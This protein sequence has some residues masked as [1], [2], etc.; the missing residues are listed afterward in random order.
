LAR[1]DLY[2]AQC[3]LAA[4]RVACSSGFCLTLLAPPVATMNVHANAATTRAAE[5]RR[6]V[7]GFIPGRSLL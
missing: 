2:I 6:H 5:T 1:F 3:F 4:T 7:L